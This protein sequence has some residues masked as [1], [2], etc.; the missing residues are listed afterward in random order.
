MST[1]RR[2]IK[3]KE[4]FRT[5]QVVNID[6]TDVKFY[7]KSTVNYERLTYKVQPISTLV[8]GDDEQVDQAIINSVR[9]CR[10]ECKNLL[11]QY[12]EESGIGTQTDLFASSKPNEG[13]RSKS[14]MA[15][16]A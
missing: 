1:E 3:E 10:N 6:G 5:E 2:V 9:E 4:T 11:S 15:D 7:V 13:K 16:A 12:R 8:H 14:S